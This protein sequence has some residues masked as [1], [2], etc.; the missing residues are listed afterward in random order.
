MHVVLALIAY[1]T[2]GD[3]FGSV[4]GEGVTPF[5]LNP[6]IN[7]NKSGRNFAKAP[8][9]KTLAF[10][11]QISGVLPA[12]PLRPRVGRRLSKSDAQQPRDQHH[13]RWLALV[14]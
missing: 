4:E 11:D 6:V 2:L 3:N 14:W 7:R 10:T 9:F 5:S 12:R 1:T 13:F 8:I